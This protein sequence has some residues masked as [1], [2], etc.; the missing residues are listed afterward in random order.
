MASFRWDSNRAVQ[1]LVRRV[2]AVPIRLVFIGLKTFL[3]RNN[4]GYMYIPTKAGGYL[5]CD[6]AEV[7]LANK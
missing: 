7:S 2:I 5:A 1:L 3:T 4:I 6:S